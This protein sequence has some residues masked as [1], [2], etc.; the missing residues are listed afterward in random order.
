MYNRLLSTRCALAFALAGS[1][2]AGCRA[3]LP[4][5]AST[6][7]TQIREAVHTLVTIRS[8]EPTLP[9]VALGDSLAMVA[10]ANRVTA[11][12]ALLVGRLYYDLSQRAFNRQPRDKA[13]LRAM[14]AAPHLTEQVTRSY[15]DR[16]LEETRTRAASDQDFRRDVE[17]GG[18]FAK[19]WGP[20]RRVCLD[21][22]GY[23][24]TINHCELKIVVMLHISRFGP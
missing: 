20:L 15:Y 17:Q 10:L 9:G 7:Y 13:T 21:N 1:G 24:T 8:E 22:E 14:L 18:Q 16:L 11:D 19:P 12:T 4:S 5:P 23:P 2:L 6:P 3:T